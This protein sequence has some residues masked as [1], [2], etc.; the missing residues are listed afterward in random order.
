V[1]VAKVSQSN[2]A[3]FVKIYFSCRFAFLGLVAFLLP[4]LLMVLLCSCTE[5][6]ATQASREHNV[7]K[8]YLLNQHSDTLGIGKIDTLIEGFM[9]AWQLKGVSVAIVKDEK[10]VYAK[11]FGYA[12]T[13]AKEKVTPHHLFRVASISKLITA[14]AVMKLVEEGKIG[15]KDKVFGEKGILNEYKNIKDKRALD[16]EI[17][18]L[19]T[20]TSG[21]KNKFRTDPMFIPLEIAEAMKAKP[22]INLD[23]I[24]QF[25]LSQKM[26][27]EAGTF[28]DYSNFGYCLLGHIIERKTGV[29]YENF[30]KEE[31]FN[32]LKIKEIAL[33]K[34][35]K[36]SKAPLEVTYYE[37]Q[38]VKP[39]P[40]F[41]GSREATSRPYGI[42]IETLSAAG[43]WTASPRD[44]LKLITAI[45]DFP[46]R[47]DFLSSKTIRLM[48]KADSLKTIGWRTCKED[49]WLR[50]GSLVGTQAVL[51]RQKDGMSWVF[52]ANTSSWRAH[53]FSYDIMLLMKKILAKKPKWKQEDLFDYQ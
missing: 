21:W 33:A 40:A 39:R 16:I 5:N 34:N 47:K 11:A 20:H 23:I 7:T 29:E 31:I 28:F 18:H 27:A 14:V 38:G 32:P 22:P 19:L 6:Q 3:Y 44:L 2:F 53:R 13:E 4:L 48:T 35:Y 52:V 25:M 41:D 30:I 46:Q 1:A 10:L 37:H 17:R 9:K 42:D 36:N 15:L 51:A 43:G 24:T 26:M 12:D 50:T 8:P 49:I 45:D